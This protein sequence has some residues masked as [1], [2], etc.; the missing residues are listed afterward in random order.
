MT[1]LTLYELRGADDRRYSLFSWRTRM[2]LAHKG[3]DARIET[4][5]L[6]DKDALA[7]S[8]GKT[9]PVLR[10][11]ETVVRDS[12]A[13]AEHLERAYPDRPSLF[14]GEAGHALT[15][16]LNAWTDRTLIPALA[17]LIAADVHDR[18]DPADRAHLRAGFERAFGQT[19]EALREGRDAKIAAFRKLLDPA[20]ASLRT[21]P[22]LS[23]EA[24]GYADYIVFSPLQWARIMSPYP[25][26]APDDPLRPWFERV[27]DLHGATAGSH[28]AAVA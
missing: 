2:A 25:V 19:L 6:T 27:L 1:A 24:P 8:G 22:F 16:L 12:W 28:P 21:R 7:F 17:P 18:I 4:V 3:L 14:G 23:G 10:D 20:R 11:G 9:V 5:L 15:H 13:I 26:L